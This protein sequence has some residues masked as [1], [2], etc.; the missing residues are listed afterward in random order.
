MERLRKELYGEK[1]KKFNSQR[2][3]L[4]L[5]KRLIN[6]EALDLNELSIEFNVSHS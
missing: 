6:K 1:S 5:L 2:R 4:I 3:I